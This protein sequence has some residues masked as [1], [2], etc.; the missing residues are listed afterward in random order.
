MIFGEDVFTPFGRLNVLSLRGLGLIIGCGFVLLTNF[1]EVIPYWRKWIMWAL[2]LLWCAASI[3][4]SEN[5]IYGLRMFLKVCAPLFFA[6]AVIAMK[7][8]ETD[9]KIGE[10]AIFW[11]LIVLAA[12]AVIC[13][14]LGIVSF[15]GALTVPSHGAAV[16]AAFLMIPVA[17]ATA[18]IVCGQQRIKWIIAWLIAVSCLIAAYGRTPIAAS[19]IGIIAII[20]CCLPLILRAPFVVTSSFLTLLIFLDIDYFKHRM[21]YKNA[22]ITFFKLFSDPRYILDH[23]DTSGRFNLWNTLLKKFYDP[24]PLFGSGLGATESYLHGVVS[25]SSARAV[26]SEYIRLSCETGWVGLLIFITAGIVTILTIY[27]AIAK[28]PANYKHVGLTTLAL[29]LSYFIFC[30]TDNAINYVN[31]LTI[32]VFYYIAISFCLLRQ[33]DSKLNRANDMTQY[34]A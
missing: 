33:N 19:A 18:K 1:E 2:F 13:K 32:Y 30:A 26:H 28:L 12:I 34:A 4:W 15:N 21:F 11:N 10:S 16:F 23:L 25:A 6:G 27:F 7:P 9:Y 3:F 14:L 22:D 5:W 29:L 20:F 8:K 17:L 31:V 24:D